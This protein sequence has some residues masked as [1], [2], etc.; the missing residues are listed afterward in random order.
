MST[1]T[2]ALT[3]RG[4]LSALP[5]V[6]AAM[7]RADLAS[8]LVVA[9][10]LPLVPVF[11]VLV[12]W[13][14]EQRAQERWQAGA[15]LA[16]H[17]LDV[18]QGLATLRSFG[19]A[20]RQ[21]AVVAE[22]TDRHR[23]ATLR[24]LRTAFLSST[25]L[26]LLGTLSVGLVAVGAGL[27]VAA[28]TLEL[29][30][31]LLVILLAPEAH[32]PLREVGARFHASADA[33]AVVAEVD[34]VLAAAPTFPSPAGAPISGFGRPTTPSPAPI[35]GF[36]RGTDPFRAPEPGEGRGKGPF[37]GRD[38]H[39]RP[40]VA[41]T[42]LRVRHPGAAADALD[43]PLVAVRAGELVTLRGPSGAGKTTA[44]R[45]LAGVQEPTAG[46][47]ERTGP[48]PLHLPQQPTLPHAR[49]V[50]A[51]LLLDGEE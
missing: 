25:A 35:S 48:A 14:T 22:V 6:L 45:V 12:G 21:V 33:A 2:T 41:A 47:V 29:G 15:R 34:A 50:A 43:L 23:A 18:V 30:P 51:A 27:R 42:G 7:A 32:R 39:G 44:L 16:G 19:R 28:G 9:C 11:A 49:T 20:Q 3:R 13:A 46:H 8:A 40:A 26:D 24:V 37:R 36:G 4:L 1:P 31:A 5:L 10:T 38:D 17:F